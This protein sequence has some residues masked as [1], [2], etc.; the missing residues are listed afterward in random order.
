MSEDIS[1]AQQEGTRSGYERVLA[2]IREQLLS[3]KLKIGDRLLAERELAVR[4]EVSRPVIREVLRALAAMGV[5]DTR[6]GHGSVVCEPD[7]A[8]MGDL[9]TLML[10]QRA[11]AI[12]DVMQARIAIERQAI[13]LAA[14]RATNADIARLDE[15]WRHIK[16]TMSDPVRGGDA[17]FEFHRQVVEA[18]HSPTLTTLYAAISS[19]LRRSHAE[20]RVRISEVDGIDAYLVDHHRLILEALIERLP[21]EADALLAQHFEI[22]TDF[23]RRAAVAEL[24]VGGNRRD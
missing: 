22:G 12:D 14:Q 13:R 8:E 15:A 16:E 6:H 9:F 11:D 7:V 3:G 2:F 19:L 18:A 21:D 4:L 1:I 17:D 20:R 24:R 10:A 5:I 23:Q